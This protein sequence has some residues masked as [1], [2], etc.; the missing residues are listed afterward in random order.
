[1]ENNIDIIIKSN[2]FHN[3]SNNEIIDLLIDFKYEKKYF[4][5]GNII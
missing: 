3:I 2:L 5:K 1:M 4:E